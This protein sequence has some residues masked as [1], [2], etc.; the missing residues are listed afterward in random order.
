MQALWTWGGLSFGYR[1]SDELWTHD[2]R[3]VGC[4]TGDAVFNSKGVY[5][6]EIRNTDRLITRIGYSARSGAFRSY[7]SRGARVSFVNYVG[8]VM[9]SGYRDF[10]SPDDL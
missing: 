7:G 5:M 1:N 2:G 6:G 9:L 3:H 4:F 8:L 10:P